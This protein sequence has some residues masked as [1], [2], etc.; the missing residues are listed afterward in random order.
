MLMCKDGHMGE[1]I[2]MFGWHR[3]AHSGHVVMVE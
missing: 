1:H 3:W 2:D